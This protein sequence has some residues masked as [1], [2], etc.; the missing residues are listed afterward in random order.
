MVPGT[1]EQQVTVDP[2][3]TE[4]TQGILSSVALHPR[5]LAPASRGDRLEQ[6]MQLGEAVSPGLEGDKLV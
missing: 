2:V 4:P 1:K 6:R 5:H 3:P